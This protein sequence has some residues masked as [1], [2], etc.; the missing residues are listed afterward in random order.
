MKKGNYRKASYIAFGACALTIAFMAGTLYKNVDVRAQ[1]TNRISDAN[2]FYDDWE[3]K[4][5]AWYGDSLTELYY[6]CDM[7]NQYFNF[8]GYNCGIRGAAV[9]NINDNSVNLWRKERLYQEGIAIPKDS[10]VIIIMAGSNDWCG[11][12]E[13]GNKKL[14]FD[15][16]GE[17]IVDVN[18]FYGGAHMMFSNISREFPNAYVLVM[19]TPIVAANTYNLYNER[20]LTSFDYGNALCE[21]AAMWGFQSFNIG[22]MMGI[23]VNN[24]EDAD[25]DMYEGIHFT[26][27]AARKAANVIIQE[28][29]KRRYYN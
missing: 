21:A 11:N 12:V 27:G 7:V 15:K 14:V 23:N 9:S 28:I 3:G 22:E 24:I 17:P 19:G 4:K 5:V 13:L 10:E 1:L 8:D 20:G 6:H 2:N 29:C 25:G 26:E 16:N 18:T